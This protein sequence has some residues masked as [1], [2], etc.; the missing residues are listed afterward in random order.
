M[1]H[2][3]KSHHRGHTLWAMCIRVRKPYGQTAGVRALEGVTWGAQGGL[4]RSIRAPPQV[5]T[6]QLAMPGW[7]MF[8][9]KRK[10]TM[11][12][13]CLSFPPGC[14]SKSNPTLRFT[15]SFCQSSSSHPEYGR[16]WVGSTD[17]V[18]AKSGSLLNQLFFR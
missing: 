9:G 16:L 6:S 4:M 15:S 17:T 13:P 2:Y 10:E 11:L 18:L 7:L 12:A 3:H 8:L 14:N 1:W 5:D